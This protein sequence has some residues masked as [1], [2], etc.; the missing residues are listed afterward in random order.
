ME[1]TKNQTARDNKIVPEFI[2]GLSTFITAR[3]FTL[4]ELL[5]VVLIIGILAAVAVPQYQKAVTKARFAEAVTN[6]STL[7]KACEVYGLQHGMPDCELFEEGQSLDDFDIEITGTKSTLGGNSCID[8]QYFRYTWPS[9]GGLP[10]AYYNPQHYEGDDIGEFSACL[11]V[12]E[13]GEI[14]CTYSSDEGEKI[15]KA[16]GVPVYPDEDYWCW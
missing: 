4:I 15:C 2:S 6:M 9:A 5:V 10:V 3:G 1:H 8:T 16:S 14:G 7:W 13:A 12:N 11:F